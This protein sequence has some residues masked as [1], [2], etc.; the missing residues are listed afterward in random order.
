[1]PG[2]RA[3]AWL[4]RLYPAAFRAE[5]G[6]EMQDVFA[7]ALAEAAK[8]G[9]AAKAALWLRE[10]RDLPANLVRERQWDSKR[11]AREA[12]MSTDSAGDGCSDNKRPDAAAS[13]SWRDALGGAGLFLL[14]PALLG[15]Y[16]AAYALL[17]AQWPHPSTT[18][19]VA[20]SILFGLIVVGF[21]AV[22]CASWIRGFPRWSFPYL[23][24]GILCSLLMR[25][26]SPGTTALGHEIGRPERLLWQAFVPALIVAGIALLV[27]RSV[28][29][30]RKL[31][32]DAW[33]DWTRISFALYGMLPI[34]LVVPFDET[35]GGALVGIGLGLVLGIGALTY[36][37]S[38]RT[39]QR[40]AAL[41]GGLAV[42]WLAATAWL[43]LFWN[44]RQV[45]WM[46]APAI[47]G[48]TA[49][50]MSGAG[51]ILMVL[52]FAPGLVGLAHW[53]MPRIRPRQAL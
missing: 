31:A 29:P 52:L 28:Q 47:G 1:M 35:H 49:A 50:A 7:S 43:T 41:A 27:T 8:I 9:P 22:A 15:V 20:G 24:F 32:A 10:L 51:A 45:F 44:E 23:G 4:L 14:L 25:S 18:Y 48:R 42:A 40:A 30:L 33:K 36:M 39:W 2:R 13:E 38:T 16:A 26:V 17:G 21:M 11:S 12:S 19:Q 5:Y 53:G 46:W 34:A 6:D 3:Y 37:R